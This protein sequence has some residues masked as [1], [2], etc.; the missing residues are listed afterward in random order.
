MWCTLALLPTLKLK[1]LLPVD[2]LLLLTTACTLG[3]L[4]PPC[5]L[6][7]LA[8]SRRGFLLCAVACGLGFFLFSFQVHEKHVLLP[9]L[10]AALLAPSAPREL[11]W[12]VALCTFSLFPL[13]RRD[14]QALP[15]CVVQ[16][17][18]GLL[19][20]M[21]AAHALPAAAAAAAR[22]TSA[23]ARWTGWR[24]PAVSVLGMLAIHLAEAALPPPARYPD[25]HSVAFAAYSCA[26]L[27][28]FYLAAVYAQWRIARTEAQHT[29]FDPPDPTPYLVPMRHKTE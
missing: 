13:L 22:P 29:P 3:S 10:P 6:L 28:V 21:Y 5:A 8:P 11:G 2:Q 9:L 4:V 24:L 14:G 23:A 25:L 27:V 17:L 18:F 19:S 15:Y 12:F 26:H 7:L 16:L 20:R 1:S